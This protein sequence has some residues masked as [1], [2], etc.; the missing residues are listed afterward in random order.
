LRREEYVAGRRSRSVIQREKEK[1][2]EEDEEAEA[3]AAAGR[4]SNF[5]QEKE[6]DEDEDE[7]EEE[8]EEWYESN[9]P[10]KNQPAGRNG[11][12][13]KVTARFAAA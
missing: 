6:E 1:D 13:A 2:E 3:E 11:G 5:E 12:R 7:D 8:D 4:P 10:R 9:A